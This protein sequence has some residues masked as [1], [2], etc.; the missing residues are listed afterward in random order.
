MNLLLSAM[1][2]AQDVFARCKEV[3][4]ISAIIH[5]RASFFKPVSRKKVGN[6]TFL[7]LVEAG[8]D[9][10][11]WTIMNWVVL[12]M[13]IT[14]KDTDMNN[15]G[16]LRDLNFEIK[17]ADNVEFTEDELVDAIQ[18]VIQVVSDHLIRAAEVKKAIEWI[19]S[20]ID[21]HYAADSIAAAIAH[22]TEIAP[23]FDGQFESFALSTQKN[24]TKASST[25][26]KRNDCTSSS[27]LSK[28]QRTRVLGFSRGER[29][30][31]KGVVGGV[32]VAG[33]VALE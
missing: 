5:D 6:T 18:V 32:K 27:N 30:W 11:H 3:L 21:G 31:R 14:V 33:N 25:Q 23:G 19:M 9:K 13:K 12:Q 7:Y 1:L 28:F 29:E 8:T 2:A 15:N 10:R 24:L 26:L 22:G 20:N 16:F 4:D 17:F